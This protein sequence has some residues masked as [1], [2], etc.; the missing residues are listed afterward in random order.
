M[1]QKAK[2]A[3]NFSDHARL[4]VEESLSPDKRTLLTKKAS[5]YS[6]ISMPAMKLK[7]SMAE[8]KAMSKS[9]RRKSMNDGIAV[10]DCILASEQTAKRPTLQP[11]QI[12][13]LVTLRN[14]LETVED[15]GKKS[16]P[17]LPKEVKK[18]HRAFMSD[19]FDGIFSDSEG[20][21]S[22][23]EHEAPRGSPQGSIELDLIQPTSSMFKYGKKPETGVNVLFAF[24]AIPLPS[25]RQSRKQLRLMSSRRVSSSVIQQG[26]R[27]NLRLKKL[28]SRRASSLLAK[29]QSHAPKEWYAITD[30]KRKVRL[31]ELLTWDNL[32]KWDFD[33]FEIDNLTDGNPLLFVGWAILSSPYSQHVMEEVLLE[34]T[35]RRPVPFDLMEGYR[36]IDQFHIDQKKMT[37]FLR[38]IE[39]DYFHEN[40]YHNN[41][42]AADVLQTL[43]SLLQEMGGIQKFQ[44]SPMQLFASLLSAVIHDVGHPGF[45]NFFQQSSQSEIALCYN[46]QS[47][48]ENMHLALAFRKLLGGKK[49]SSID[50]FDGMTPE[51]VVSCRKLMIGNVLGTDMSKHFQ[52]V[53]DIKRRIS[54]MNGSASEE[55]TI[56][57]VKYLMHAA[58]ISNGAK[59]KDI[60]VNWADRCLE[61]FFRQGDKEK[62]MGLPVSPLCN[63][64]TV[65]RPESQKGFIE[66]IIKPTFELLVGVMPSI[67][68]KIIPILVSN[69]A[70]WNSQIPQKVVDGMEQL[71][72]DF[73]KNDGVPADDETASMATK[74]RLS[75][76][77][78]SS[79]DFDE[80]VQ[81]E[82]SEELR[83]EENGEELLASG[84][85]LNRE[86]L[87]SDEL[88]EVLEED[89]EEDEEVEDPNLTKDPS[90]LSFGSMSFADEAI[91]ER[92]NENGGENSSSNWSND[93]N[94][95]NAVNDDEI[96]YDSEMEYE[97]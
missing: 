13:S 45:N 61:E 87:N 24:G 39:K 85:E 26:G 41:I 80:D 42:H 29:V 55:T 79:L 31:A 43:H 67:G 23:E 12:Q 94:G 89:E 58:D 60:A 69:L 63:R 70:F 88:Q 96:E 1:R 68:S 77:S 64:D 50:I 11:S 74:D 92:S 21:T 36:F 15:Q 76:D 4:D 2:G 18:T 35:Q 14:S 30:I 38:S 65:S 90:E 5:G 33:M 10:L 57:V 83:L 84:E 71:H 8:F 22:S 82:P 56:E 9:T 86:R 19:S 17:L 97:C 72:D 51:E 32:C 20:S 44:P 66:F 37:N 46:D 54:E 49:K 73:Q 7:S 59:P 91:S 81:E 52:A 16:A 78:L 3:L 48:L 47:C 53:N 95:D 6:R 25:P 27:S 34:R 28:A 62:E 93:D 75:M 40:P